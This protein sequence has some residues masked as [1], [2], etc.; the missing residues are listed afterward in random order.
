MCQVSVLLF[1][2]WVN[3]KCICQVLCACSGQSRL[4]RADLWSQF[5]C[6]IS[7][8]LFPRQQ[9]WPSCPAQ[10]RALF[11]P[12]PS[13]WREETLP[14]WGAL[15][16]NVN[17]IKHLGSGVQSGL[18]SNDSIQ[19]WGCREKG[20]LEA[21]E[22]FTERSFYYLPVLWDFKEHEAEVFHVTSCVWTF[23]TLLSHGTKCLAP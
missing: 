7:Q 18:Q 16:L 10:L 12:L 11:I 2:L 5:C 6:S 13:W 3:W 1:A 8:P 19:F 23:H 21:K 4:F 17:Y 14:F 15:E 9:P 22:E 20:S